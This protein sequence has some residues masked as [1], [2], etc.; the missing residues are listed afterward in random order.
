MNGGKISEMIFRKVILHLQV[1]EKMNM[2]YPVN[3]DLCINIGTIISYS[4]GSPSVI[5]WPSFEVDG[6]DGGDHF[7]LNFPERAT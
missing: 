1:D 4:N 7:H 3:L 5:D 6:R 2:G